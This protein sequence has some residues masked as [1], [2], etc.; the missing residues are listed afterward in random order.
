MKHFLVK[1]CNEDFVMV[2]VLRLSIL[3][4]LFEYLSFLT[5]ILEWGLGSDFYFE[6]ALY[7]GGFSSLYIKCFFYF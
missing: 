5:H 6:Y 3:T 7:K 4:D 2:Y 1:K